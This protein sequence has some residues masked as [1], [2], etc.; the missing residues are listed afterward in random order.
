MANQL[1]PSVIPQV[2]L[3]FMN[4]DHGE[5]VELVNQLLIAIESDSSTKVSELLKAFFE[6]NQE[7]FAREEEQMIRVNFPPYSCHKGE[8]ERVLEEMKTVISEWEASEDRSALQSYLTDTVANWL[9]NHIS[10][11]DT[12]TAMFVRQHS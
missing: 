11:M 2:A 1:N 9:V 4:E 8:H 7:H 5:A 10:T 3:D 12:V 6:H